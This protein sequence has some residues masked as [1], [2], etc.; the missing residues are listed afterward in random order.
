MSFP[1][2]FLDEIKSRVSLSQVVG[3]KVTWDNR[4]SV[5]AKGD[6]WAP[7]PFHQEKTAS[8]HIND[9]KGFYYC[10]GCQEKGDIVGFTMATENMSFP[11][12]VERLAGMA[13]LEM[14]ARDPR[15][16]EKADA[17][18]TL[19]EV[20]ETS[21]NFFRLQLKTAAA[22]P[23]RAYLE[24][25]GLSE[26]DQERFQIGFAPDTRTALSEHLKNK[27]V[28]PD[29]ITQSGM[30][31]KP[32]NGGAPYDR[33]RGRIMF[34]IRDARGQAIAFG[35]RALDPNARAKY[36]N[37]PETPLFDKGK[38]LYNYAPARE[39]AGKAGTLVVAEGYMDVIALVTHGF[40]ATVAPNG[41]AITEDQLRLMWRLAPEPVIMLDGDK[42]GKRAAER[43]V[44]LALPMLEPG[45]SLRFVTLPEGL[46]PDDMLRDQGK[47][48][49]AAL[50]ND[51]SSL[52]DMLWQREVSATELDTPERRAALDARLRTLLG[53]IKDGSVRSHYGAEIKSRRRDLFAPQ[54]QAWQPQ[55]Q[56]N[57][58]KGNWQGKRDRRNRAAHNTTRNS[59]LATAGQDPAFDARMRES[60]IISV[61]LAH[62]YLAL[63]HETI[64]DGIN[65]QTAELGQIRDVILHKASESTD[66]GQIEALRAEISQEIGP[67]PLEKLDRLS[68]IRA[69]PLTQPGSDRLKAEAALLDD[70]ARHKAILGHLAEIRDA[71]SEITSDAEGEGLTWR[72]KE[73]AEARHKAAKSALSPS[74]SELDTDAQHAEFLQ[75]LIDEQAWIKK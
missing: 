21:V 43:L 11:E 26:A 25:R 44:N 28:S 49:V 12:A 14:P 46:D 50:I 34:P 71:Q 23:A 72:L 74:G 53:E 45:K 65:F 29:K 9:Q 75:R 69:N 6:Y 51:A 18:N 42:A 35:G 41:T 39:A 22:A 1:P 54:Q 68:H 8:F 47:A 36:L 59:A 31:I 16:R 4:K 32:D 60:T 63:P 13:G 56:G 38:T 73:A 58:Q 7:C 70:I 10:F 52:V 64:L 61:C 40:E 37:S 2:G 48:A 62:P 17:R 33:F 19:V 55:Q 66:L 15:A 27:S 3:Q 30:A 67:A 24:K 5:P 20:M 57:F